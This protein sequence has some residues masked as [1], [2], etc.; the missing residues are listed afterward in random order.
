MEAEANQCEALQKII[1]RLLLEKQQLKDE[2]KNLERKNEELTKNLANFES[3]LKSKPI[4]EYKTLS[5][6]NDRL[7][8]IDLWCKV[9]ETSPNQL[10]QDLKNEYINLTKKKFGLDH[11]LGLSSFL[12]TW[13]SNKLAIC[14]CTN[15]SCRNVK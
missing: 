14:S 1:T 6:I 15:N 9:T 11:G 2:V 4:E 8:Q 7:H 13:G 5:S 3:F 12:D 10:S